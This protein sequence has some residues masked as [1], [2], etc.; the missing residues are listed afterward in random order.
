MTLI[1]LYAV[2]VR[3]L[4]LDLKIPFSFEGL[5]LFNP[6][7]Y[8]SPAFASSLG[9][10]LL[11]VALLFWICLFIYKHLKQPE[12]LKNGR[13]L[14][15]GLSCFIWLSFFY[16]G[17]IVWEL[18]R[19]LVLDSRISFNASNILNLDIYSSLGFLVIGLILISFLLMIV[20]L[21]SFTGGVYANKYVRLTSLGLSLL[22]YQLAS[23]GLSIDLNYPL[24][25]VISLLLLILIFIGE[26]E[27][28]QTSFTTFVFLVIYIASASAFSIY[29]FNIKK[30][31]E[32]KKLFASRLSEERDPM[33]EFV[34]KDVAV[35][36]RMDPFIQSFFSNPLIPSKELQE[37]ME[38]LYF[39]GVMSQY[40]MDITAF[41]KEGLSIKTGESRKLKRELYRYKGKEIDNGLYF[42]N[43]PNF[44]FRY[45]ALIEIPNDDNIAG[46]LLIKFHP[47]SFS[48]HNVYPEL[49]MEEQVRQPKE[50]DEYD[51]AIYYDGYIVS[52]FGDYPYR[53]VEK[54][55]AK[56]SI[57]LRIE[58]DH[59]HLLYQPN[60]FKTVVVTSDR[61]KWLAYISLFSILFCLLTLLM[62]IA[63]PL[64]VVIRNFFLYRWAGRSTISF[65][66]R[67]HY[68]VVGVLVF[69]FLMIGVV[70]FVYFNVQY[71]EYHRDRLLRKG[72]AIES[73]IEYFIK[74]LEYNKDEEIKL[75]NI[76]REL[77]GE[78]TAFSDIHSLD[79]NIYDLHG[80]LTV[81]SQPEI[82]QKGMLSRKMDPRALLQ[83]SG[84]NL[85][86]FVQ[87]ERI[88]NLHYLAVYQPLRNTAGKRI[89]YLNIP[90][91]TR[92]KV[93][94]SEITPFLVALTNVYV[95]LLLVAGFFGLFISNSITSS[96]K[97]VSDKFK[98]VKLG[99]KNTPIEWESN[100][101]IG[102][103]VA[104]YNKMLSELERSAELLAKSERESA[105]REMAKQVAHEI[106]NPLTPMKLSIQHL[107]RAISENDPKV[108]DMA[109]RVT[110]TLIEQINTLSNIA[111]E[112]S[113]FA[114]MPKTHN[115]LINI[116]DVLSS[117]VDLYK[118][119]QH[120]RFVESFLDENHQV[121]MDRDQAIRIFNNLVQNAVEAIPEE[122][123]GI[124]MVSITSSE[125]FITVSVQDNGIGIPDNLKLKVF[126]P[127]FT[128]KSSGTGL[129]LA[130]TKNIV[131]TAGGK[132]WFITNTQGDLT[133][134]TFFVKLPVK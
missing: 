7:Y 89:A 23:M 6:S 132:I 94:Q 64:A 19:S 2:L 28:E 22:I 65:G 128:S 73:S 13:L 12:N 86:K 111:T 108:I 62:L 134:T 50:Y 60:V 46:H 68:T 69:S 1:T 52:R 130:M 82:F 67:V 97:A 109:Q 119:N 87:T 120:I 53:D 14:M 93:L 110:T 11:Q 98:Q 124:V 103:L 24:I 49:L 72:K 35:R 71:E 88:G 33:T 80:D 63:F 54:F 92:E 8:A 5:S 55:D 114:Q 77:A 21:V 115:E 39:G 25:I 123:K 9:E 76:R 104:E 91:F 118:G 58:K 31:I 83:M 57:S 113:S 43:D 56:K 17:E 84:D 95:V 10:L 74:K 107:Q 51:Y 66:D 38:Y 4:L 59:T 48:K 36:I 30:E 47:K 112:F 15:F 79:I 81:S 70:T 41:N 125:S 16:L 106:K 42:G 96:L 100:D 61:D 20:R 121:F 102:L 99:M 116:G 3:V 127:N 101:E 122:R 117:V 34:F 45:F 44:D 18:M 29:Q 131:E 27:S 133:G 40:N 32:Q 75:K 26:K 105:W 126:D 85:S 129:G 37:R 78:I 90:Y